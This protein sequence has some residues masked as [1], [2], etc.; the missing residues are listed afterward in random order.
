[1]SDSDHPLYVL[2]ETLGRV[3]WSLPESAASVSQGT[4][5]LDAGAVFWD[6]A[7]RARDSGDEPLG[8]AYDLLGGICRMRLD[9]EDDEAP[10]GGGPENPL[11]PTFWPQQIPEET[12]SAIDEMLGVVG[13]IWLHARLCDVVHAARGRNYHAAERAAVS[14]GRAAQESW[15]RQRERDAVRLLHRAL[16]LT[17]PY[18]P[19]SQAR[20]AADAAVVTLL[21]RT[22]EEN[23][24]PVDVNDLVRLGLSYGVSSPE[25][26]AAIGARTA[27]K[28]EGRAYWTVARHAW[29]LVAGAWTT[30]KDHELAQD[31]W[32]RC[33][34]TYERE[35]EKMLGGTSDVRHTQAAS[36]LAKGVTAYRQAGRKDEADRVHLLLQEV[37]R[38]GA[39]EL[40][41]WGRATQYTPD[42]SGMFTVGA[43]AVRGQPVGEAFVGLAGLL[44]Y[45]S[46][47]AAFADA[48]RELES[49]LFAHLFEDRF[50]NHEGKTTAR[51]RTLQDRAVKNEA[52]KQRILGAGLFR[53][54]R[55]QLY[56]EHA[57]SYTV[58]VVTLMHAAWVPT[59]RAHSYAR[60]L[61]A[62]YRGEWDVMVALLGPQIEHSVRVLL[63]E[64]AGKSTSSLNEHEIQ[65]E[66]GLSATLAWPEADDVLGED[67]TFALRVLL[68]DPAGQNLRNKSAH[69]LIADGQIDIAACEYLWWLTLKLCLTPPEGVIAARTG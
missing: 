6:R 43:D 26:L 28:A 17:G 1:M 7:I 33:A 69:G 5:L 30:A 15:Q 41:K 39:E 57:L 55:L 35:A 25:S 29:A 68:V 42:V 14:L 2:P 62:G 49:Y 19:S 23:V 24:E 64:G 11:G 47:K 3:D 56:E 9:P 67:V 37:Q 58:L 16:Q 21:A 12:V 44:P 59:G 20:A 45:P 32:L 38:A 54:A 40:A 50:Q 51:G 61:L 52:F 31:A 36:P 66:Y 18:G 65:Q 27:E 46:R 63:Y 4:R 60:A 10:L 8:R 34:A 53:G 22:D 48:T 13:D